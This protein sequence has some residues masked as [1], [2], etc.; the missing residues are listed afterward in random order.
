MEFFKRAAQSLEK[1]ADRS[2]VSTHKQIAREA[3]DDADLAHARAGQNA[4]VAIAIAKQRNDL[5]AE[6]DSLHENLKGWQN[7]SQSQQDTIAFLTAQLNAMH[8][9]LTKATGDVAQLTGLDPNVVAGRYKLAAIDSLR[10]DFANGDLVGTGVYL[11]DRPGVWSERIETRLTKAKRMLSQWNQ[12]GE[13]QR[14]GMSYEEAWRAVNTKSE[15]NAGHVMGA[16]NA[17]YWLDFNPDLLDVTDGSADS[18]LVNYQAIDDVLVRAI[19]AQSGL[20][21]VGASLKPV[22]GQ[23]ADS[24]YGAVL[25]TGEYV[26]HSVHPSMQEK[27]SNWTGATRSIG[28]SPEFYGASAKSL[29]GFMQKKL[30]YDIMGDDAVKRARQSAPNIAAVGHSNNNANTSSSS[31][32]QLN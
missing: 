26:G 8:G 20:V 12:I 29:A 22:W 2:S 21:P 5:Q 3:M 11:D 4:F 28:L 23:R 30:G 14:S 6:V 32:M 1:A 18:A 24:A 19:N 7:Q 16:N 10:D 15:N 9:A 25:A 31:A 13:N 27:L 17:A